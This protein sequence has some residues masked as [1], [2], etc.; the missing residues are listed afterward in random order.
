MSVSLDNRTEVSCETQQSKYDR[1]GSAIKWSQRNPIFG[2]TFNQS[3]LNDTSFSER[4]FNISQFPFQQQCTVKSNAHFRQNDTY[5]SATIKPECELTQPYRVNLTCPFSNVG[6]TNEECECIG[7]KKNVSQMIMNDQVNCTCM[8]DNGRS[9]MQNNGDCSNNYLFTKAC[10]IDQTQISGANSFRL[11]CTFINCSSTLEKEFFNA[12]AETYS[13]EPCMDY[14]PVKIKENITDKKTTTTKGPTTA[15]TTTTQV[16]NTTTTKNVT[17][18]KVIST[19]KLAAKSTSNPTK[20][21]TNP[22]ATQKPTSPTST[23]TT[24]KTTPTTEYIPSTNKTSTSTSL[25][26]LKSTTPN[27]TTTSVVSNKRDFTSVTVNPTKILINSVPPTTS[28]FKL[29][30]ADAQ[31]SN[32]MSS[33][34]IAGIMVFLLIVFSALGTAGFFVKTRKGRDLRRRITKRMSQH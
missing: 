29:P 16:A 24:H 15:T 6:K 26:S 20:P 8:H 9:T 1:W 11:N 17:S 32:Q 19:T 5:C 12:T 23:S 2:I 31:Q 25:L 13:S 10:V 14:R 34:S 27:K 4:P 33:G 7:L 30:S 22:K 3:L 21:S 28:V 18:P